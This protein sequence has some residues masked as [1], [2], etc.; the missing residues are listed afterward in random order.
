MLREILAKKMFVLNF[1]FGDPFGNNWRD[2]PYH[3]IDQIIDVIANQKHIII[4]RLQK[5][6]F[7]HGLKQLL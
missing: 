1:L 7:D 4:D 2:I 6:F 5:S 3:L